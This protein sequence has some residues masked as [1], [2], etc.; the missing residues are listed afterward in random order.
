M[1][2]H[3]ATSLRVLPILCGLLLPALPAHAQSY[4]LNISDRS[5]ENA[6]VLHTKNW[7]S[8]LGL[9]N[10]AILRS[11]AGERWFQIE[12]S[13]G[14]FSPTFGNLFTPQTGWVA[15]AEAAHSELIYTF[16]TVPAWATKSSGTGPAK[17]APYDI[18]Q[19]NEPCEKPLQNVVSP[20][21]N[22]IWKEWITALMQRD[23]E[24]SSRP[25]QPL[26]NQCHIRN[27]ETWNEFNANGFWD[28]S[29]AHL[30][31]M[32]NDMALVVR[33]YCGDCTIVAGSTSAGGIGRQGG[34]ASGSGE[35][36][37]ALGEFLD[38]WHSIPNASLPDAI[39]F[40][41][42]PS[43]TNVSY[44][45]FPETNVSVND[46]KCSDSNVPNPSCSFAVIDQPGAIRKLI[47]ARP[48]LPKNTPIWNTES[49][50]NGNHTLIHGVDDQGHADAATGLLRQAF[51]SREAIL[52]ANEGVV[53]NLWY[54][55]DHQ[56][57]G[58]L[59]G[60]GD[61]DTS[62]SMKPCP[63][64]P[65]IPSGLT[66]TGHAFVVLYG[67]LHGATFTGP[68]R[69][70]GT[71]WWCPLQSP[72]LGETILA[73]TTSWK[74][75]ERGVDLPGSFLYA[76]TLDASEAGLKPGEKPLLEMRPRLFSNTR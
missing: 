28:D 57:D 71:Q 15:S 24:V 9:P 70:K 47:A 16:N 48:Y 35:Y 34:G 13:R 62:E 37:K 65:V 39:S 14:N 21:G 61:A 69:S 73:W 29:L 46:P 75:P 11:N 36:D 55:A 64:D 41:A 76:R 12:P 3:F 32:A 7:P 68:C 25:A 1:L 60:F 31:K 4:P 10:P 22:C 50:W 38:A 19:K 49:G 67:W 54:E 17:S 2:R 53:V 27:F 56:C 20:T 23:C 63:H 40:H 8:R 5:I 59:I 58:T 42:Y 52:M 30:A 6:Y 74:G 72:T 51:F 26:Q 44:P 33:A 43:R 18:D 45:P 66:P